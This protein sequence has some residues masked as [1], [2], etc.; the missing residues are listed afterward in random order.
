MVGGIEASMPQNLWP[1]KPFFAS[2]THTR[3]AVLSPWEYYH[4]FHHWIFQLNFAAQ[5][6]LRSLQS[7]PIPQSP[8]KKGGRQPHFHSGWDEQVP[9]TE[10]EMC[11]RGG[12]KLGSFSWA[13]ELLAAPATPLPS[14]CSH[15]HRKPNREFWGYLLWVTLRSEV[16]AGC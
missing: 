10:M 13:W 3:L 4:V 7:V 16:G 6:S 5:F 9:G 8:W 12:G 1:R 11:T 14:F 2:C 15:C